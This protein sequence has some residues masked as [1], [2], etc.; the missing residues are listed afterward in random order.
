MYGPKSPNAP[1]R[2]WRFFNSGGLSDSCTKFL[3][4]VQKK[5]GSFYLVFLAV[6]DGESIRNFLIIPVSGQGESVEQLRAIKTSSRVRRWS[7]VILTFHLGSGTAEL[8]FIVVGETR[9]RVGQP[10]GPALDY[11]RSST[12]E[13]QQN[14]ENTGIHLRSFADCRHKFYGHWT[15]RRPARRRYLTSALGRRLTGD[16]HGNHLPVYRETLSL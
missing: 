3:V 2:P 12:D 10:D 13:D 14:D 1:P 9:R 6:N 5:R 4:L 15:K 11:R 7:P 8:L 16:Q